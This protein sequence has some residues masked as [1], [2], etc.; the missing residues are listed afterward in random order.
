MTVS[1]N[2]YITYY[3]IVLYVQSNFEVAD[4]YKVTVNKVQLSDS[5]GQFGPSCSQGCLIC[6]G[7]SAVCAAPKSSTASGWSVW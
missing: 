1:K 7:S 3:E 2:I 6:L 4:S 5:P